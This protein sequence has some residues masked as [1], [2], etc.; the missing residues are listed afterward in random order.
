MD[1][2]FEHAKLD[3]QAKTRAQ[4]KTMKIGIRE[5]YLKTI[6]TKSRE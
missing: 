6:Y 4:N 1:N 2:A 3:L 5:K